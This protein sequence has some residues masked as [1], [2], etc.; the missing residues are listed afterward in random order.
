MLENTVINDD[1]A[2]AVRAF[3]EEFHVQLT[4]RFRMDVTNRADVTVL[5]MAAFL[6]PRF[7]HMN[8]VTIATKSTVI[9][10]IREELRNMQPALDA[11]PETAVAAAT[12]SPQVQ[13]TEQSQLHATPTNCKF[14]YVFILNYGIRV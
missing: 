1:D 8:F 7:S 13:S 3:K 11:V 5:H 14:I 10:V 12:A 6:D 4:T 9:D 2:E